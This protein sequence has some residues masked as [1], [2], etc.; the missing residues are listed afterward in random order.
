MGAAIAVAAV[1]GVALVAVVVLYERELRSMARFLVRKDRSANERISVEFATRGVRE[2]AAAAN[3]ELDALRDERAAMA[4]RQAAFQ[5]DLAALSHD[6]RTPL[7][8]AQGYLQLYARSDD[9]DERARCLEEAAARL[10]AMRDLTDKLFEYAKAADADSPLALERVEALP[11]LAEVLAGAYPQFAE[12]GW[13]PV[14]DF[15]DE[16]AAVLADEEAL[17]RVFGNLLAN[18][19]R[20]GISAPRIAQRFA[21]APET[22]LARAGARNGTGPEATQGGLTYAETYGGKRG[23]VRISFANRVADPTAIEPDAL[24]ERFYRAD[25]ARSGEGSG[26][27]LAIVANLCARMGGSAAARIEGEELVIDVVL[28]KG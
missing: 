7:A 16:N 22:S 4:E 20:Y 15:E 19:L 21:T 2:V 12:R 25:T 17:S 11:V 18:A 9:P 6:I 1:L 27:G 5:R 24:F 14:L 8:G 28:S 13:D 3:A 23:A 26:L 10:S